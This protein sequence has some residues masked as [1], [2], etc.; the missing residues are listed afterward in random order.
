MKNRPI[1]I[2]VAMKDEFNILKN[3]LENKKQIEINGFM[4]YEGTIDDYPIV[5]CH[6]KI[7]T[8]NATIATVLTIKKYNPIAIINQGTAG[9]HGKDIHTGD[10]II[11][12]KT[13]NIISS[14]TSYKKKGEGSNTLD[15][16]LVDFLEGEKDRT[17]YQ[18]ADKRLIKLAQDIE[19]SHGKVKTGVIGSGDIWDKEFDRI[20]MLNEKYG[21]LCEDMESIAIYTVANLFKVPV[22]GIKV[23]SNNEILGE[24]FQ[25]S[26]MVNCQEF[27]YKFIKEFI[28]GIKK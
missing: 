17:N 23:I 27:C 8:I 21:T 9:G 19:F 3:K 14:K 5:I 25:V 4:F 10:I 6:C 18:L 20:T 16:E 11:G 24:E 1:A 12:K 2:I 22:I 7:M 28:K 13:L 26:T 15:W